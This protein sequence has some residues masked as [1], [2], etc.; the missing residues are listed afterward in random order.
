[1]RDLEPFLLRDKKIEEGINMSLLRH[2]GNCQIKV[3]VD[4]NTI[5]QSLAI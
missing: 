5:A 1:M 3:P 2:P 4:M